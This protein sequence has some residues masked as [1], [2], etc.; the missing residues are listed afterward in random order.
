MCPRCRAGAWR[1]GGLGRLPQRA[2]QRSGHHASS[3]RQHQTQRPPFWPPHHPQPQ[4]IAIHG[5]P[6]LRL[7]GCSIQPAH[8]RQRRGAHVRQRGG[9]LPLHRVFC[10]VIGP[11]VPDE[12]HVEPRE[13]SP[14]QRREV[15][16]VG[17]PLIHKGAQRT[18]A[19]RWHPLGDALRQPRCLW[20]SLIDERWS[21]RTARVQVDHRAQVLRSR[22]LGQERA[23]APCRP[24]PSPSVITTSTGCAGGCA[25]SARD[26]Q[27][28]GH[29]S[30]IIRGARRAWHRVAVRNHRQLGFPLLRAG[31][32]DDQVLT[33]DWPRHR[34]AIQRELL[35]VHWELQR[36]KQRCQPVPRCLGFR[37]PNGARHTRASHVA[38][39]VLLGLT[40]VEHSPWLRSAGRARQGHAASIARRLQR[41]PPWPAHLSAIAVTSE[42]NLKVRIAACAWFQQACR[43][44]KRPCGINF[45]PQS[46]GA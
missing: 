39:Q 5:A 19:R 30:A 22:M 35:P 8:Q 38:H 18:G 25:T 33:G 6:R 31:D 2:P 12:R 1:C 40:S 24:P 32:A 16:V 37:R 36:A 34:P 44:E 43:I 7:R 11:H 3:T 28:A 20:T 10:R 14:H 46:P 9:R 26:A 41:L 29:A 27:R 21:S 42:P 13:P 17:H 23:G 4:D 15:R 45:G